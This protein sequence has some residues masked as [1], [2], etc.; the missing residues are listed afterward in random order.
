LLRDG[1]KPRKIFSE[2]SESVFP[3]E[4]IGL[5]RDHQ[6]HRSVNRVRWRLWGEEKVNATIKIYAV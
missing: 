4:K 1:D 2:V 3:M 5:Q 6:E